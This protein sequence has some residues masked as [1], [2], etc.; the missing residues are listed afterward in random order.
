MYNYGIHDETLHVRF[1]HIANQ[2]RVFFLVNN[3]GTLMIQ[4]H[5]N[6]KPCQ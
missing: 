5:W 1:A 2:L 3:Y 4:A 6:V